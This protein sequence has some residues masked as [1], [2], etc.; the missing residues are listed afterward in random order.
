MLKAQIQTIRLLQSRPPGARSELEISQNVRRFARSLSNLNNIHGVLRAKSKFLTLRSNHQEDEED[1]SENI[2]DL[3]EREWESIAARALSF[4]IAGFDFSQLATFKPSDVSVSPLPQPPPPPLLPP[5]PPPPS[6]VPP[7]PPPPAGSDSVDSFSNSVRSVSRQEVSSPS[8]SLPPPTRMSKLHW[9][10][11]R[12]GA[13]TIWSE[14]PAVSPV[15]TDLQQFFS[16]KTTPSLPSP[17]LGPKPARKQSVVATDRLRDVA[18]IMKGL[19]QQEALTDAIRD[20]DEDVIDRDQ[21]E[22]LLKLLTFIDEIDQLRRFS[23]ENPEATLD[24]AEKFLLSLASIP[25]VEE[26][27][28]FWSFRLDCE[29]SEEEICRPVNDLNHAMEVLREN[30]NFRLMLSLILCSG[31]F[32]NQTA[33][34][35]F[36][37]NDLQ[38][39]SLMKDKTKEKTLLYHVVRKALE[40]D[41][42]FDGFDQTFVSVFEAGSRSDLDQ[43]IRDLEVME[44]ECKKSLRFVLKSQNVDLVNFIKEVVERVI[45]LNKIITNLRVKFNQFMQWLGFDEKQKENEFCKII[46]DFSIETNIILQTF[47]KQS[48]KIQKNNE[49]HRDEQKQKG[50][51]QELETI[52]RKNL[53]K[54]SNDEPDFKQPQLVENVELLENKHDDKKDEVDPT[55]EDELFKVLVS[56]FKERKTIR[57]RNRRRQ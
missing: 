46:Y 17:L 34:K 29:A 38:K 9:K 18:I 23:S 21:I 45:T 26:K 7:P 5:P 2:D 39:V 37:L 55:N 3:A 48:K 40:N 20:M 54:I 27:L 16:L 24:T 51:Q 10:T 47:E 42:G 8:S 15:M 33:V 31:N 56:G 19:P 4:K 41:P 1:G 11:A 43:V 44:E 30:Q 49:V 35:A 57:R 12:G 28:S 14:L 52:F 13:D 22:K 25:S 6:S 53:G 50:V 36:C 32:L